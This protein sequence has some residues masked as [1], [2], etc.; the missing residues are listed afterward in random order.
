MVGYIY[1]IINNDN[2]KK[3]IGQ[4]KNIKKRINQHF[5][6]NSRA[7]VSKDILTIGKENFTWKVLDSDITSQEQLD[8]L[9]KEY[10]AAYKTMIPNGYNLVN[11][12]MDQVY[13]EDIVVKTKL[14]R[15]KNNGR[16]YAIPEK[17]AQYAID[18]YNKTGSLDAVGEVFGVTSSAVL[19]FLKHHNV[20]R[21]TKR[22]IKRVHLDKEEFIKLYNELKTV[23][24][25]SEYL[26][27]TP[28]TISYYKSKYGLP[29]KKYKKS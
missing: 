13:K 8:V 26:K 27:V 1:I 18:I 14:N 25:I 10:I 12:R 22:G 20:E 16:D 19:R 9:E 6:G 23:K 17:H 21:K 15:N 5:N 24:A 2:G 11:G 3:Y 4:T 28:H 7:L 29:L